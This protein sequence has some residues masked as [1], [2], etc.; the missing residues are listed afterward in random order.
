[1]L[2]KDFYEGKEI[3]IT[4]AGTLAK[5]LVKKIVDEKINYRG[6]RIYSHGEFTLWSAK[7]ELNNIDKIAYILGD[8]RDYE[9]LDDAMNNV[10]IVFHTAAIKHLPVCNSNPKEAVKTNIIGSMNVVD[11]V[12]ENKVE[13]AIYTNT[14][15]SVYG[16]NLYGL[17]KAVP[18]KLF[19][20]GGVY[21]GYR[22]KLGVFRY[23]NVLESRG[24]ILELFRKQYYKTGE[25]TIT[26]DKMRRFWITIEDVADFILSNTPNFKGGEIIIPKMKSLEVN[27][28]IKYLYP[29]AKIKYIGNRGDEKLDE[30]LI[31]KEESHNCYVFD[32]KYIIDK[33]YWN[34]KEFFVNSKNS[35]RLTKEEFLRMVND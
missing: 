27:K 30:D 21:S 20:Y 35:D 25:I 24:S 5:A 12:I 17:S 14:D 15:K 31:N 6:I 26:D 23:G 1:M 22:T 28:I 9:A 11:A 10:D 33:N 4:G 13:R 29:G 2:N 32:D 18:E 16:I 3:L 7:N 34:E 8:I 19:V